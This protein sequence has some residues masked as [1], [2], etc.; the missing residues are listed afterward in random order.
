MNN[1]EKEQDVLRVQEA[2]QAAELSESAIRQVARFAK[3]PLLG[4]MCLDLIPEAARIRQRLNLILAL[5]D[6]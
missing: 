4:Q 2:A 1:I 3:D 6:N 5:I